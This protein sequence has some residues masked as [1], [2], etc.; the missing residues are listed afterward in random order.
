ML[1]NVL[2]KNIN[3]REGERI[4]RIV[5]RSTWHYFWPIILAIILI[6]L[7]F[8]LIYPLFQRGWWGMAI[9]F[10]LLIFGV[11]LILRIYFS[12]FFTVFVM[13]N[14]RVIDFDQRGLFNQVVTEAL[15]GKIGDVSCESRGAVNAILRLGNIYINLLNKGR[16]K[17]KLSAIKNPQSVVGDILYWQENYLKGNSA[18]GAQAGFLLNKIKEK[19]GD[20]AFNKLITD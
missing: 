16:V 19:M 18:G 3:L 8:F 10:L 20:D 13:T 12:H 5:R 7:P 6:I 14:M 9:F 1:N 17:L 4:K 11:W 15:Y 2:L